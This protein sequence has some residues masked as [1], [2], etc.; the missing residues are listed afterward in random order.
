MTLKLTSSLGNVHLFVFGQLQRVELGTTFYPYGSTWQYVLNNTVT[1][2]T[3]GANHNV[4]ISFN[5]TGGTISVTS[6]IM[7][8][9]IL[10]PNGLFINPTI[11]LA[12]PT[13]ANVTEIGLFDT[14]SL[15]FDHVFPVPIPLTSPNTVTIPVN[16]TDSSGRT[17][18]VTYTMAA[19]LHSGNQ[20]KIISSNQVTL[21]Y[22]SL[23]VGHLGINYTNTNVASIYYRQTDHGNT[24]RV[25][26]IYPALANMTCN[27]IFQQ[28]LKNLNFSNLASVPFSSTEK[29]SSWLFQNR[30]N[31]V[32]TFNCR[33]VNS[34]EVPDNAQY[35]LTNKPQDFP[36]V[37]QIKAFRAGTYGTTGQ[38][39]MLD[40]ITLSVVI[41]SMIGFNRINEAVGAFFSIAII[42]VAAYF[43]ILTFAGMIFA[44]VAVVTVLA[45]T[46]VRKIGG[47]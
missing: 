15:L 47:F 1:D 7:T 35:I 27:I 17:G 25:S 45:V 43:G 5:N 20:T 46:S 11:T 42:G 18:S 31:D 34:L 3:V 10:G 21:N 29:N 41:F 44:A 38:F 19:V 32:V 37:Q 9:Y 40:I 16:F 33:D 12:T 4:F 22:G 13:N 26:L 14:S 8:G 36:F 24:T 30:P 28:E 2:I 23:A 39:G 6:F